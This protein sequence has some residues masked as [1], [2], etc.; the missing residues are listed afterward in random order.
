MLCWVFYLVY[1]RSQEWK[2]PWL[3]SAGDNSITQSCRTYAHP[4]YVFG[5]E[6][7][8]EQVF[9]ANKGMWAHT[10]WL[11]QEAFLLV[12]TPWF[13][14]AHPPRAV[15]S[16]GLRLF[17]ITQ[18]SIAALLKWSCGFFVGYKQSLEFCNFI[19]RCLE[20]P[21]NFRLNWLISLSCNSAFPLNFQLFFPDVAQ[22]NVILY[23][24]QFCECLVKNSAWFW[25]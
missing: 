13:V 5:V 15:N 7:H 21:I 8:L 22:Q 1:F 10:L 11:F 23:L 16:I 17:P 14:Y 19:G 18:Y 3:Q 4:K 20:L 6:L 12:S 24:F 25:I 2:F 9:G